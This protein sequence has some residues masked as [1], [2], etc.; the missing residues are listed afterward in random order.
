MRLPALVQSQASN[1][2][3]FGMN[4]SLLDFILDTRFA[5]GLRQQHL[6]PTV[7][8][9]VAHGTDWAEIGR[10]IHWDGGTAERFYAQERA[11][12]YATPENADVTVTVGQWADFA[13]PSLANCGYVWSPIAVTDGSETVSAASRVL[14]RATPEAPPAEVV[15]GGPS[16]ERFGV[17]ARQAGT[18]FLTF[19]QRR[20]WESGTAPQATQTFRIAVIPR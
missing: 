10:R 16:V 12:A 17:L 13:L 8:R 4:D 6:L 3:D 15:C 2:L 20:P 18:V 19:E 14:E 1:P 9:L 11:A 5:V 7:E